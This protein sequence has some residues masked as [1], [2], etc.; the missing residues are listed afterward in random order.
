MA[1]ENWKERVGININYSDNEDDKPVN[2][3]SSHYS[4]GEN[5][6]LDQEDLSP[7][8]EQ[9]PLFHNSSSES[10]LDAI[11]HKFDHY[12]TTPPRT[13]MARHSRDWKRREKEEVSAKESKLTKS[14]QSLRCVTRRRSK[15]ETFLSNVPERSE[16]D[17]EQLKF[18]SDSDKRVCKRWMKLLRGSERDY[19]L[20]VSRSEPIEH[21]EAPSGFRA[22]SVP[23]P[24]GVQ[25]ALKVES[26]NRFLSLASTLVSCRELQNRSSC[27]QKNTRQELYNQLVPFFGLE[28]PSSDNH[29]VRRQPSHEEYL[30]QNEVKDLIWLELQAWHANRTPTEQDN[31]LCEARQGVES[32]LNEIMEYRFTYDKKCVHTVVGNDPVTETMHDMCL[33]M[34]CQC[35]IE[36]QNE[37]IKEV[38]KLSSRLEQAEALYPSSKAFA[39]N[40]PLYLSEQFVAR[41]K[42]MCLWLNITKQHRLKLLILGRL[43]TSRTPVSSNSWPSINVNDDAD[44]GHGSG[45]SHHGST[46]NVT[47]LDSPAAEDKSGK[48]RLSLISEKKQ[49]SVRFDCTPSTSPSD[50]ANSNASSQDPDDASEVTDGSYS[51]A[52]AVISQQ[53]LSLIHI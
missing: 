10:S 5:G 28:K 2:G 52:L 43:F 15:E 18:C 32:L 13:R 12:G 37:A 31:Y 46:Q 19:K 8:S 35:C 14:F 42:A 1:D 29:V 9:F 53:I 21:A 7:Q 45:P 27:K 22:D 48:D 49:A 23:V 24:I 17:M 47:D 41:V 4:S 3:D 33:S 25:P 20:D 50:S 51:S 11:L 44:S 34:F 39:H 6:S 36:R 30:W 38:E 16:S 26:S 40:Y